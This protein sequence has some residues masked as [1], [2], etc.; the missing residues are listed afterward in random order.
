LISSYLEQA[1][2]LHRKLTQASATHSSLDRILALSLTKTSLENEQDMADIKHSEALSALSEQQA[3]LVSATKD[4]LRQ[5]QKRMSALS[6]LL[7]EPRIHAPFSGKIVKLRRLPSGATVSTRTEVFSLLPNRETGYEVQ[8]RLPRKDA[9]LI[10]IG[11]AIAVETIGLPALIDGLSASVTG[12]SYQE[13][14]GLHVTADLTVEATQVL[15]ASR[16]SGQILANSSAVS[17]RIHRIAA[18]AGKIVANTLTDA[19]LPQSS[20]L[21]EVFGD[22]F[23]SPREWT[24]PM[25]TRAW[26]AQLGKDWL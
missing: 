11:D 1:A 9:D 10:A 7:E 23:T 4:A 22:G 17:V 8:F 20:V 5:R 13:T 6:K 21:H 18:P 14:S 19:F 26:I 15:L 12:I 3:E 25:R 16:Y 2:T 24:F